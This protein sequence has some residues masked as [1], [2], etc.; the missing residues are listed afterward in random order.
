MGARVN[1]LDR[2]I[3][4]VAPA[5]G[6]RRAR[7][8]AVLEI[9]QRGYDGASKSRLNGSWRSANTSADTEIGQAGPLLRDRMRDLVRNNPH[10]ANAINALV[11]HIVGEGIMPRAKTGDPERDKKL[12][13]LFDKWSK[14]ADADGQLDFYGLQSLAVRGMMESGDGIIRRRRRRAEDKLPVPLQLQVLETDLIDSAKEGPLQGGHLAIQGIEFNAIGQRSAYWLFQSHPGNNFLDPRSSLVSKP[15]PAGDIAHVYEKQR[16]QVRGTPWGA[17]TITALRDLGTYEEAELVRKKIE[18]CMVG[19]LVKKTDDDGIGIPTN[20]DDPGRKPGV[21]DSAGFQVERFEPGMFAFAEGADDI[22]FNAP[23]SSGTTYE[24]YKRSMLHT[25]AAGFRI[26]HALLTGDLTQVNYSSSK[27]GLEQF[28]RL[29]SAV[30]WQIVI[31]MLCEP[32]WAWFCEAAYLAGEIDTPEIAV[33]WNPPKFISAD[34]VKDATATIMEVRAGLRSMPEA[35]SATGRNPAVVL[36]ETVEW[37]KL[38]DKDKVILDSDPRKVTKQGM[39]QIDPADL[40]DDPPTPP[41]G[42]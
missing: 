34:P 13:D 1:F 40:A 24:S 17:P 7:N 25:V 38:L 19:V 36:A 4:W 29:V 22:K 37:N 21:Y 42:K 18:S 33:E 11:T 2:A 20:P 30:Q 8:R 35:I 27:V 41:E 15:V 12:N 16:T 9:L 31:P 32:V 28:R 26:P 6:A 39:Y 14:K 23:A 10:A 3:G 5:A